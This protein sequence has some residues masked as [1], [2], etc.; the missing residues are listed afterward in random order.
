[1]A[2]PK[3]GLSYALPQPVRIS[4]RRKD[5]QSLVQYI[6]GKETTKSD[7][8]DIGNK[9]KSSVFNRLQYSTPQGRTSVFDKVG[10]NKILRP[11]VFWRLKVRT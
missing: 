2:V 5:K 10:N 11:S 4:G 6:A 3:V 1:M 8:E 7:E 9:P